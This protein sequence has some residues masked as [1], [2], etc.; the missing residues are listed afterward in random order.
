MRTTRLSLLAVALALLAVGLVSGTVVRHLIQVAPLAAALF[1]AQRH[2]PLGAYA[3]VSLLSFWMAV[4]VLIWLFLLGLSDV[5]DG[6][7]TAIEVALT[8]VIGGFCAVGIGSGIRAGRSLSWT[9]R[10]LTLAAGW[11]IQVG[12]M[13]VSFMEQVAHR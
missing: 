11:A 13:A 7:Y 4:M 6:T 1:L 8:L 5:A 9:R 10:L 12:V 2:Q 3:A